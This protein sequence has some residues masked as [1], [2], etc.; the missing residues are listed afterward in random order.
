MGMSQGTAVD[1]D[2]RYRSLF[3]NSHAVMLVLDPDTAVILD[4]NEAAARFY[5]RS[6]GDLVGVPYRDLSLLSTGEIQVRIGEA[7]S[8]TRT[9]ALGRHRVA[10]GEIRDVEVYSAAV[11]VGERTQLHLIIYDV[12]EKLRLET[13]LRR[14]QRLDAVR[15]LSGG[16]AHE[17]NN[18]LTVVLAEAALLAGELE[19]IGGGEALS[20]LERI[21]AAA[22]R[23]ATMIRKLLAYS[24][25]ERLSPR[26]VDVHAW[27]AEQAPTIQ[28]LLPETI[29]VVVATP[30]AG[31]LVAM[32]D[33]V[34]LDQIVLNLVSNARDAMPR[35]GRLQLATWS[36]T[37]R[38]LAEWTEAA[39][40]A[41]TGEFVAL[42][43]GD[44]GV[45]MDQETQS[46]VFEPFSTTLRATG[47]GLG[48]PMVYGLVKQQHG[49]VR[50]DSAPGRGTTVT[51]YLPRGVAE[52]AREAQPAGA[53]E[54]RAGDTV[55]LVEDEEVLR[56]T[57][58]RI[59]TRH[60]FRVIAAADGE[61][62]LE[63]YRANASRIAA[64]VSDLVMPK[65]GGAELRAAL[66]QAGFE[67]P[68][69]LMS[70]YTAEVATEALGDAGV[71]FV[72]KPWEVAD[73][74]GAVRAAVARG[75]ANRTTS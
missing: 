56:S 62:A 75:A 20:H 34:A 37:R 30:A 64:V 12:T 16:V 73:F 46:R 41:P 5:G 25:Q 49:F 61:Q 33:P 50:V 14:S 74:V 31:T 58:T 26:P 68:F 13:Q 11:D 27:L 71:T 52:P 66:R 54:S 60:G 72:W 42:A 7:L 28:R 59:L 6:R 44:T 3:E 17:L 39:G 63:L 57:A 45:G 23:A 24:R 40:G 38:E 21:E 4:A 1:T 69:V 15:R 70:G 22:R 47:K 32:A 8:A 65:M 2:A 29:Q 67:P 51:L 10:G 43:V 53:A 36:A 19:G 48:L 18:Q 55:L 9:I 35:G